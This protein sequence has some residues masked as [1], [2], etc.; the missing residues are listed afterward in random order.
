[1]GLHR[2]CIDCGRLTTN[3]RCSTCR[4]GRYGR[5][6][7]A[8]RAAWLPAV[9]SGTA[10]CWRCH[11]PVQPDDYDLGHKPD[12]TRHPEHAHCNRSSAASGAG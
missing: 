1:M 2:T 7:Q 12:G 10:I 3:G 9:I 11:Q 8:E 5:A 6:H 4:N